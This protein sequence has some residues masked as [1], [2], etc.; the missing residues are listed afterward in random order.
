LTGFKGTKAPYLKDKSYLP[1]EVVPSGKIRR[2][3]SLA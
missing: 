2:G 1:L 3:L